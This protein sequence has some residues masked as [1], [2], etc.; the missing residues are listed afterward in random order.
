MHLVD[1]IKP[2]PFLPR[3][4]QIERLKL[5]KDQSVAFFNHTDKINVVYKKIKP[6]KHVAVMTTVHNKFTYVEDNKTEAHIF[7]NASKGGVNTFDMM[8]E[9]SDTRRK[10]VCWPMCI[11]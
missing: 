3:K 6:K 9:Y 2:K 1:K 11:F 10:T 7:Y 8:C 5:E 4:A